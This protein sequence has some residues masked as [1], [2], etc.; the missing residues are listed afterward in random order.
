MS[1]LCPQS[2]A[3]DM[4][5]ATATRHPSRSKKL[6]DFLNGIHSAQAGG[7]SPPAFVVSGPLFCH[8]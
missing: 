7:I 8:P 1:E 5:H 3:R 2:E 4:E 6:K